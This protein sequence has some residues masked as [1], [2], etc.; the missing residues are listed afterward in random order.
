MRQIALADWMTSS[1][2]LAVVGWCSASSAWRRALKSALFSP[3]M[4]SVLALSPCFR[5]FQ[6]TTA[7]PLAVFG[8]VLFLAFRRFARICL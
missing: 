4:I 1:R 3:G 2:S 7:R 8:P 6:R 5:P